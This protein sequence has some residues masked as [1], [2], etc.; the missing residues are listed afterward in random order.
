MEFYIYALHEKAHTG[1]S[2][3]CVTF[4]PIKKDIGVLSGLQ[5]PSH[6]H[7]PAGLV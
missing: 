7:F 5:A 4:P 1:C 6:L 2:S 3:G